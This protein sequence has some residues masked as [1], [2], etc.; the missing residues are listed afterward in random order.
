MP[1][2]IARP[3]RVADSEVIRLFEAVMER[4]PT[5]HPL[6][7]VGGFSYSRPSEEWLRALQGRDTF[8][9]SSAT[10]SEK[11]AAFTL[12]FRRARD[13]VS[14]DEVTLSWRPGLAPDAP[15]GEADAAALEGMLEDMAPA[16]TPPGLLPG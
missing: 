13:G 3:G 7:A 12:H 5:N 6:M 14:S 8:L 4:W 15:F 11:G 1:R 10:V 2:R 16:P 9:V